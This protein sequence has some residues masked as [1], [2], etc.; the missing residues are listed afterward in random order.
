MHQRHTVRALSREHATPAGGYQLQVCTSGKQLGNQQRNSP[1]FAH[2]AQASCAG[3]RVVLV[4]SEVHTH[5]ALDLGCPA[6]D[7]ML[8]GIARV[9]RVKA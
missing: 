5:Q 3:V 6:G 8:D 2:E 7:T 4:R 9:R 1:G